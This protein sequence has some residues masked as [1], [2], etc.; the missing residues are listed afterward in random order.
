MIVA[1]AG[2]GVRFNE[3]MEGHGKAVFRHARK[4]SLEALSKAQ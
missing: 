1:K 4:L 2:S 3:H